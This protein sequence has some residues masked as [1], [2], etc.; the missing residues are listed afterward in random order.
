MNAGPVHLTPSPLASRSSSIRV[1]HS[2]VGMKKSTRP[3][4]VPYSG[5]VTIE[6]FEKK[7]RA[8]IEL[9]LILGFHCP[10][11]AEFPEHLFVSPSQT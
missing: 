9:G 10:V 8:P 1:P 4:A 2:L 5:N 6:P 7:V 11:A 3:S